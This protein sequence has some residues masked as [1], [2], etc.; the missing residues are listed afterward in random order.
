MPDTLV[1][2][3]SLQ[4]APP[5]TR[6]FVLHTGGHANVVV[7]HQRLRSWTMT[8]GGVVSI[9]DIHASAAKTTLQINATAPGA[10]AITVGC[11]GGGLETW[12]VDVR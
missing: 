1:L 12:L 7:H 9:A 10:T 8:R 4:T 5:V 6:H 3:F 2:A 11:D